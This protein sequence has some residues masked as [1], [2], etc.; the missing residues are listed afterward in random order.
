VIFDH[1]VYGSFVIWPVDWF[2][3]PHDVDDDFGGAKLTAVVYG[4]IFEL[5][6]VDQVRRARA[7]CSLPHN[8]SCVDALVS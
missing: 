1:H 8:R 5:R 7:I 4:G 6:I 2:W 3:I